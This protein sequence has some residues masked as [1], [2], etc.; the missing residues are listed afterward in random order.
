MTD[1]RI[2]TPEQA[3]A[4]LGAIV[5][6]INE[7]KPRILDALRGR[8]DPTGMRIEMGEPPSILMALEDG[9]VLSVPL[10]VATVPDGCH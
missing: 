8:A 1:D 3:Q 4:E 9:S 2:L 10:L 7:A 6:A 5:A